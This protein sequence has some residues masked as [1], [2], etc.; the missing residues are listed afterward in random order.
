MQ[1]KTNEK[2]NTF[3]VKLPLPKQITRGPLRMDAQVLGSIA[4]YI[5]LSDLA[6][7]I[8]ETF[9]AKFSVNSDPCFAAEADIEPSRHK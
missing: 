1:A 9:Y 5:Y 2:S 3:T 6:F 4:L 8:P 7:C